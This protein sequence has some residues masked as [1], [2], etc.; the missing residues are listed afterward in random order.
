[1]NQDTFRQ[2]VDLIHDNTKVRRTGENDY[3]LTLKEEYEV[4]AKMEALIKNGG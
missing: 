2:V 4:K 3:E 1:M